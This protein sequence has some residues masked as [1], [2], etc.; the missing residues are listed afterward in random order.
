MS[1]PGYPDRF[2]PPTPPSGSQPIPVPKRRSCP[3]PSSPIRDQN[4]PELVFNFDFSVSP[5]VPDMTA[6]VFL[7][8]QGATN[9]LF[10]LQQRAASYLPLAAFGSDLNGA[11]HPYAHEPFL[12]TV[13]K[14]PFRDSQNTHRDTDAVRVGD[15]VSKV[16]SPEDEVGPASLHT[17]F[18]GRLASSA[19]SFQPSATSSHPS[20]NHPTDSR[21]DEERP[22]T[23]A[24]RG[25]LISTPVL[26]SGTL[27]DH[28]CWSPSSFYQ[29]PPASPPRVVTAPRR[30][31]PRARLLL[32]SRSKVLQRTA[33]AAPVISFNVAQAERPHCSS[34]GRSPYPGIVKP[35]PR[36]SSSVG[37]GQSLEKIRERTRRMS[38]VVGRGAGRVVS[39][40]ENRRGSGMSLVSDEDIERSLEKDG[41]DGGSH[42]KNSLRRKYEAY[43]EDTE[44]EQVQGVEPERGRARARVPL[45]G[46]MAPTRVRAL[47]GWQWTEAN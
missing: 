29:S 10:P 26:S 16:P 30:M 35:R 27:S 13:P 6:S 8:N 38:T 12:Y 20:L 42:G 11:A 32:P 28:N 1:A 2:L 23:S 4:S 18:S 17:S 46:A 40:A 7:Q 36:R 34:R 37:T 15:D 45:R 44:E 25:Q 19:V 43:E 33:A 9:R 31:S 5:D 14:A 3:P 47:P 41:A 22:L 24:F 39:L 21:S